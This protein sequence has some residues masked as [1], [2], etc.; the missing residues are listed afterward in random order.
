ML[1][2]ALGASGSGSA[3]GAGPGDNS[4]CGRSACPGR[5]GVISGGAAA[6]WSVYPGARGLEK[7]EW[8]F[9]WFSGQRLPL[10][11]KPGRHPLAMGSG[12]S[13]A[14]QAGPLPE[15][16]PVGRRSGLFG[17]RRERFSLGFEGTS[18]QCAG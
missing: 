15:Q 9:A 17:C 7:A 8:P 14:G 13:V 1:L 11:S 18:S 10:Q 16:S 5:L 12:E 4:I 2:V 6:L 3:G